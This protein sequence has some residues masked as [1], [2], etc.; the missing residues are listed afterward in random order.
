MITFKQFLLLE[1][2]KAMAE[3]G[4]ERATKEDIQSVLGQLAKIT[5]LS[6]EV[7]KNSLLGSTTLTLAGKQQDSGDIDIGFHQDLRDKVVQAVRQHT[8][9]DGREISSSTVSFPFDTGK[10]KVQVDLMFVPDMKWAKFAY[11]AADDGHKSGVRNELLHSTLRFS[12][13]PGK[14]LRIQD[15]EGRDIVRASRSYKLDSG[16]ERIFK[17]APK[18]K[19]GNGRVKSVVK[20]TP[21]QVSQTLKDLGRNDKFSTDADVIRDP[22]QF[23]RILFGKNAKGSDLLSTTSLISLIKRRDD[24]EQIFKHAVKAMKARSFKVPKDLEQY[25]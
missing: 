7:L 5:G 21:H 9:V 2:G 24:A 16:V 1:G 25:A 11:H 3:Y 10:K 18:R 14:D 19:D 4:V 23:A 12:P 6:G 8:G 20:A 22:D 15:D 17:V 13:T